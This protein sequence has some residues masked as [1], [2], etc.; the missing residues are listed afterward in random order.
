MGSGSG[1]RFVETDHEAGAGWLAQAGTEVEVL[2][3]VVASLE[4]AGGPPQRARGLDRAGCSRQGAGRGHRYACRQGTSAG[5]GLC[6][7]DGGGDPPQTGPD[8]TH[9]TPRRSQR[10]QPSPSVLC[11]CCPQGLSP[12][13]CCTVSHGDRPVVGAPARCSHVECVPLQ[14]QHQV[15]EQGPHPRACV[16]V[17]G[18]LATEPCVTHL[19]FSLSCVRSSVH[20]QHFRSLAP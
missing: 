6:S 16:T 20:A 9:V 5:V 7:S 3:P 11:L 17:C 13:L 12:G 8:K 14:S 1:G 2:A 4:P 15:L 10:P 18:Q 19:R